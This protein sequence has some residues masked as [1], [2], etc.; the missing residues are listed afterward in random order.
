MHKRNR[1]YIVIALVLAAAIPAAYAATELTDPVAI[2]NIGY[3]VYQHG[4]YRLAEAIF[5]QALALNPGYAKARENRAVVRNTLGDYAGASEDLV[6]LLG[7]DDGNV[8]YWYDLGVNK[9][10]EFRAG[11]MDIDDFLAGYNAYARAAAID[12]GYAHVSENLAVLDNIR[13]EFGI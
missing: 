8:Q 10:A 2:N 3:F 4:E 7:D 12:K 9:I 6:L 1:C 13:A 11:S 5:T